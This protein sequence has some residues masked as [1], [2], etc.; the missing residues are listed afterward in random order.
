MLWLFIV[1]NMLSIM[2]SKP[3]FD[4]IKSLKG[5]DFNIWVFTPHRSMLTFCGHHDNRFLSESLNPPTHHFPFWTR[6]GNPPTQP[7]HGRAPESLL[8]IHTHI[9]KR[10]KIPTEAPSGQEHALLF[11]RLCHPLC[12]SSPPGL[13]QHFFLS[14][15]RCP[16]ITPWAKNG[17]NAAKID[18]FASSDATYVKNVYTCLVIYKQLWVS[19]SSH[20]FNQDITFFLVFCVMQL[21]VSC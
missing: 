3:G 8:F 5:C 1:E 6:V 18:G 20:S 2:V 13:M 21:F 12:I 10:S 9:N 17:C 7:P 4:F 15:G 16:C 14:A 19:F 11:L